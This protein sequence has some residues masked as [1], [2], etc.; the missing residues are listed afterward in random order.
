MRSLTSIQSSTVVKAKLEFHLGLS[1]QST[2][3]IFEQGDISG[4]T[5]I[6]WEIP[7]GGGF[8]KPSN[9]SITLST[10]VDFIKTY[11]KQIISGEGSLKIFV[12]SDNF[13]PSIGRIRDLTRFPAD[14]NMLQLQVY[15]KFLDTNPKIPTDSIV[16]SYSI[17]H[18]EV[19]NAD[20]GYPL[21]YGKHTRPFYMT[22]VDSNIDVLLGPRNVSSENHVTSL[23]YNSDTNRGFDVNGK[24]NIL[25]NKTWAQQ[26]G[27]TNLLSGGHPFE[28]H[29]NDVLDTRI[30]NYDNVLNITGVLSKSTLFFESDGYH[31]IKGGLETQTQRMGRIFLKSNINYINGISRVN[32]SVTYNRVQT[33][34]K[35]VAGF[36]VASGTVGLVTLFIDQINPT[37]T[38]NKIIQSTSSD[39]SSNSGMN[40]MLSG[41][42]RGHLFTEYAGSGTLNLEST[43]ACSMYLAVTMLSQGY[44]NYSIMGAQV[45]CTHLAISENPM[46]IARDIIDQTSF[47]MVGAQNS[48]SQY[49]TSSYHFQCFFG[50]RQDLTKILSE[51]GKISG[52]YM[53]VGDSGFIN[54]NTYQNSQTLVD[55]GLIAATIT[56][57][58]FI[59]GSLRIRDN[60]LGTTVFNTKKARRVKIDYDYNFATK[61]YESSLTANP[62]NNAFCNSANAAGVQTVISAK[63]KYIKETFTSSLYMQ[64]I[65]RRVTQD[66]QIVEMDLPARFFNLELSDV[67]KLQHPVLVGSE[68]LFQITKINPDY[69]KGQVKI[70][71]NEIQ[72][73]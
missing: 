6:A 2:T 27:S 36:Y 72:N 50:E 54:F 63:T 20:F 62:N 59:A 52:A 38:G 51:F 24:W 12:N 73:L 16:D 5:G 22:A 70:T 8:G 57:T 34:T 56:T 55:S 7:F 66:E 43:A 71:A 14:L 37:V 49:D 42:Q 67:V 46:G 30:F 32:A 69:L 1:D 39:V 28:I 15:D 68:S 31:A 25:V 41:Y 26:S 9:Y 29:D 48:Q 60:P 21:Y 13:V 53:W 3:F 23:W 18:P 40:R 19:S 58:D 10:S 64:N 11:R 4:L 33:A 35:L 61:K 17:V 44:K 45:N 47:Q 65:I